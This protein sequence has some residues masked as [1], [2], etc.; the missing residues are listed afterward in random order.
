[1]TF[2]FVKITV[3][4]YSITPGDNL[5]RELTS[6]DS[7]MLLCRIFYV[8]NKSISHRYKLYTNSTHTSVSFD[9]TATPLCHSWTLSITCWYCDT[10]MYFENRVNHL[11]VLRHL[12]VLREPCQS[13]DGTVTPL[14]PSWTV[15]IIWWYCD[16]SMSFVNRVNHLLN[17]YN[18]CFFTCG[19]QLGP[20]QYPCVFELEHLI[21]QLHSTIYL[22]N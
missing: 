19:F 8:S 9:G 17:Q 21:R 14:C 12:Y 13:F 10:S 4:C 20:W 22:T 1:M 2:N 18:V 16:T 7:T 3:A 11:L 15:S 6:R 5:D